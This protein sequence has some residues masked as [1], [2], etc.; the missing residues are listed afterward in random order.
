MYSAVPERLGGLNE[1]KSRQLR[2]S[3]DRDAWLRSLLAQWC[4]HDGIPR[5]RPQKGFLVSQYPFISTL[6]EIVNCKH[7]RSELVL[8]G[9]CMKTESG[10]DPRS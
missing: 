9:A 4:R 8:L 1:R 7:R 5:R 10:L 3:C 2:P 6:V